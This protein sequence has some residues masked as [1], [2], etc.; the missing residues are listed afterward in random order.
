MQ[1][2]HVHVGINKQTRDYVNYAMVNSCNITCTCTCTDLYIVHVL[3]TCTIIVSYLNL[4]NV[5]L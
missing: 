2:V 3:C 5:G 4:L 1:D